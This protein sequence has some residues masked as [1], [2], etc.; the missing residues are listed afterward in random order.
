MTGCV[1]CV[2]GAVGGGFLKGAVSSGEAGSL[3]GVSARCGQ[4]CEQRVTVVA[5]I[6]A[7]DAA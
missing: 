3:T 6:E 7:R 1:K 5:N 2:W 4:M